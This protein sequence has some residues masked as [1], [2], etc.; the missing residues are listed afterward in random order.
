LVDGG[1]V[2]DYRIDRGRIRAIA[3]GSLT[4]RE[5][6]GSVVTIAVSPTASITLGGR[7]VSFDRLRPGMGAETVRDGDAP[8]TAVRATLR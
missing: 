5:K 7:V 6:D 4:L 2:H 8:A 1:V 3:P